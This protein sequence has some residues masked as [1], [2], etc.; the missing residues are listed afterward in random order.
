M[1]AAASCF[2]SSCFGGMPMT[3]IPYAPMGGDFS[4][5]YGIS[6]GSSF[7]SGCFGSGMEAYPSIPS[8]NIPMPSGPP[9][10]MPMP[11]QAIPRAIPPE[12]A[13]YK[14]SE[15]HRATV[16]VKLPADAQL[17][18]EGRLLSLSS[19]ERKFTTPPLPSGEPPTA[20]GLPRYW[21]LSRCST[22]A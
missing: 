16:I 13:T 21:G 19:G 8:P 1:Y 22:E 3:A 6:Y 7:G 12:N 15:G 2:G 10:T 9:M 4:Q 20:I 14:L 17:Y 18:A 5:P 11:D